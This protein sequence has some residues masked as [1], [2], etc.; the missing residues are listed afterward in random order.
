MEW[1]GAESGQDQEV[2]AADSESVSEDEEAVSGQTTSEIER[3]EAQ[4]VAP[5]ISGR[6]PTPT[7]RARSTQCGVSLDL[8]GMISPGEGLANGSAAASTSHGPDKRYTALNAGEAKLLAEYIPGPPR[9][10]LRGRMRGEER[11]LSTDAQSLVPLEDELEIALAMEEKVML[12][13]AYMTDIGVSLEMPTGKFR[14]CHR[15]QQRKPSFYGPPSGKRLNFR[16]AS[17]ST[18]S[19]T[20][21]ALRL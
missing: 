16:N 4:T 19:L 3:P 7:P 15:L 13:E 21:D 18:V 10:S 20:L 14:T 17:R 5:I 8:E 11:R 9:F 12:E 6:A 2:S 1:E